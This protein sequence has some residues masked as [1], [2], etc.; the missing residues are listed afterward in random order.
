MRHVR[1]WVGVGGCALF[2]IEGLLRAVLKEFPFLECVSAQGVI[3]AALMAVRTISNMNKAKYDCE[4]NK[5][6]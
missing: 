4:C 5:T 2:L 3:I 1:F 6:T